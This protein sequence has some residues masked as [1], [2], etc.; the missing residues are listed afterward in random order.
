M[1]VP[2]WRCLSRG[3]GAEQLKGSDQTI[4]NARPSQSN[5]L[6]GEG[7]SAAHVGTELDL[8]ERR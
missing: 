7:M 2:A 4:E 8:A 1:D 5:K 3:R 6:D